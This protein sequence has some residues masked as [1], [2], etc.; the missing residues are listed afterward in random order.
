MCL[1]KCGNRNKGKII[2]GD[3]LYESLK[4][5]ISSNALLSQASNTH[6]NA[7]ELTKIP[8]FKGHA[9]IA[10]TNLADTTKYALINKAKS[11]L[12]NSL[13]L[14]EGYTLSSKHPYLKYIDSSYSPSDENL[15]LLMKHKMIKRPS[16]HTEEHYRSMINK[17]AEGDIEN[18]EENYIAYAELAIIELRKLLN[19]FQSAK[20]GSAQ[21]LDFNL[22]ERLEFNSVLKIALKENTEFVHIDIA[23]MAHGLANVELLMLILSLRK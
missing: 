8:G 13:F 6:I 14:I 20:A 16:K 4:L 23:Y 18:N 5:F 15:D 17:T 12:L 19:I 10:H 11:T 9:S 21:T 1:R 2:N 3:K 22:S 7:E